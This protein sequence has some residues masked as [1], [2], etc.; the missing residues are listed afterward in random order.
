MRRRMEKQA[1]AIHARPM[2]Q[3][4][5]AA[6]TQQEYRT[7]PGTVVCVK[8]GSDAKGKSTDRFCPLMSIEKPPWPSGVS[9]VKV[10]KTMLASS[11]P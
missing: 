8:E 6:Q 10:V 3:S 5:Y 1:T 11:G 2:L 4:M 7:G 9:V